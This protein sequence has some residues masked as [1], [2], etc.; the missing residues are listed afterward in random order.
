MKAAP[1]PDDIKPYVPKDASQKKCIGSLKQSV[2]KW[3]LEGAATPFNY[4]QLAIGAST[5]PADLH[6]LTLK[7]LGKNVWE[8]FFPPGHTLDWEDIVT[9]QFVNTL[10]IALEKITLAGTVE[11]FKA[12]EEFVTKVA[13]D[14]L[15]AAAAKRVRTA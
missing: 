10:Q 14:D 2:A 13:T 4:L 8:M 11:S 9:L 5:V 1:S 7:I 3:Q 12:A 15:R 6:A